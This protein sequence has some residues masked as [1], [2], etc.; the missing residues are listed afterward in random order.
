MAQLRAGAN[1][2][3]LPFERLS[4]MTEPSSEQVSTSILLAHH[5]TI[6]IFEPAGS[7]I[8]AAM[9]AGAFDYSALDQSSADAARNAADRIKARFCQSTKGIG[10]DLISVK[11]LLGY[12]KF[13]KW[14]TAEF[15]MDR[16]TA[17]RYMNTARWL[18][19]KSDT[20]SHL[21]MSALYALAAPS[22]PVAIVSK[23]VAEVDAGAAI[24]HKQIRARFAAYSKGTGEE[25]C[26]PVVAPVDDVLN[27]GPCPSAAPYLVPVGKAG[28]QLASHPPAQSD[29]SLVS[30]AQRIGD[31]VGP[32]DLSELINV[33]LQPAAKQFASLL[34]ELQAEL[35]HQREEP[36]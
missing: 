36:M 9:V 3:E 18:E 20:L 4:P 10:Q 33:M 21:T 34:R 15:D 7:V 19:D 5:E 6:E 14:I 16:R 30:L 27:D 25:A 32:F 22:A 11:D 23:I 17:E 29:R 28:R 31:R 2:F 26:E 24:T 8:A 12:S 13:G 1:T 35:A